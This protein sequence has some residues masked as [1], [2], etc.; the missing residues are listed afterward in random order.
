MIEFLTTPAGRGVA[1]ICD[2]CSKPVTRAADARVVPWASRT[3]LVCHRGRCLDALRLQYPSTAGEP[4][5]A[6]DQALV[7]LVNEIVGPGEPAA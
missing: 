6:L 2:A 5:V 4:D 7:Q 1:V 3:A